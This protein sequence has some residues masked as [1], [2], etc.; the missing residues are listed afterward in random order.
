MLA[1]CEQSAA[2]NNT[3]PNLYQTYQD[4]LLRLEQN[5]QNACAL[6]THSAMK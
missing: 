6:P 2:C 4:A 3:F 1:R 5:P